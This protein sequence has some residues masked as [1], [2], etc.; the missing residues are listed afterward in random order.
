MEVPLAVETHIST[1]FF[2]KDRA[3]KLL[4]PI[5]TPYLDFESVENRLQAVDDEVALNR[6]LAPDVYLGTADVIEQGNVV[7]RLIVMRRLPADRRLATL[8]GVEDL[9]DC[10]RSVAK[11]IA[12][13]HAAQAPLLDAG[14]IAGRD[15]VRHNW[16][17]NFEEM[18]PFVGPIFDEEEFQRVQ[19]MATRFLDH[20]SDL[21]DA[22][23]AQG[24]VRDG[25]G[26]LT[27]EDIFCTDDGPQILDCLAFSRRLRIADV[28]A[29]IAFLVMDMD[30]LAGP[31][32]A[33]WLWKYY[34]EFSNEH[35]PES[36]ASH[37]VA[38]RAHVRA[39][40]AT[41]RHRQ[42]DPD[43]AALARSY[44]H[45]CSR[46]LERARQRLVVVG[47]TPGTGKSTLARAMSDELGWV[48]LGSDALRKELTGRRHADHEAVAPGEGIYTPEVS[49]LTYEVL[50]DRATNLLQRGESVILDASFNDEQHRSTARNMAVRNGATLVELECQ[51]DPAIAKARVSD[52][53]RQGSDPSDA[54][55]EIFDSLVAQ[56]SPWPQSVKINTEGDRSVSLNAALAVIR[57]TG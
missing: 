3:Y 5:A 47:G 28:L 37:Y 31:D 34:A 21:F 9:E 8:A 6:R 26:D 56:H 40:V 24:M 48:A 32:T 2:T 19:T 54:R 55:P 25:H 35:H 44:H 30:R 29:D 36:L 22:R 45:L 50:F 4:K 20:R 16:D 12:A 52:R 57:G 51:L 49:S 33:R 38:Y 18:T 17:Q 23:L 15:A 10:L 41:L 13:F 11:R 1:L 43:A 14:D 27:A 53:L 7:D 39:K 42:G 46:H